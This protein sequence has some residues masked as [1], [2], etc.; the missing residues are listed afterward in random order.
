MKNHREDILEGERERWE[1]LAKQLMD[2][3]TQVACN[4]RQGRNKKEKQTEE[5]KR[6]EYR[7]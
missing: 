4:I 5:K 7:D 1:C 3:K 2:T 6:G